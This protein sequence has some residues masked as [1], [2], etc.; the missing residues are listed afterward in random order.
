VGTDTPDLIAVR[1]SLH[2]A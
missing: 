1:I 2:E